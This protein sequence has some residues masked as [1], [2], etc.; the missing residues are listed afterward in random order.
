MNGKWA[1][2]IVLLSLHGHRACV[3]GK[4]VLINEFRGRLERK[5]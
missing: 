5:I 4:H 1:M 3:K 2:H